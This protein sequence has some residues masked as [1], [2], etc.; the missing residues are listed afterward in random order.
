[1][2]RILALLLVLSIMALLLTACGGKSTSKDDDSS[3]EDEQVT[4]E[5]S[6]TTDKDET[7]TPDNE[8]AEEPTEDKTETPDNK[9]TETPTEE[10]LHE[11]R[12]NGMQTMFDNF[13]TFLSDEFSYLKKTLPAEA[14]EALPVDEDTLYSDPRYK[15]AHSIY[16]ESSNSDLNPI[17]YGDNITVEYQLQSYAEVIEPSLSDIQTSLEQ[18]YGLTAEDV[19]MVNYLFIRRGEKSTEYNEGKAFAVKIDDV[20]YMYSSSK[21]FVT[22]VYMNSLIANVD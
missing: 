13:S 1:M 5:E 14:L 9:D 11:A 7:E 2:K 8:E 21:G 3:S 4:Q 22:E 12:K 19:C 15:E 6:E 18:N 16:C 10:D 20:W 17:I